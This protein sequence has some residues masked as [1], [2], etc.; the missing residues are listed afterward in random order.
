MFPIG[1]F[2]IAVAR[3][4]DKLEC[5]YKAVRVLNIVFRAI[6]LIVFIVAV[7]KFIKKC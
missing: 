5:K 2:Y 3:F 1:D 6:L 7:V 4:V